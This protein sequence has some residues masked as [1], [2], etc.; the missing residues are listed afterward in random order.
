MFLRILTFITKISKKYIYNQVIQNKN[1][2]EI[3]IQTCLPL[4]IMFSIVSLGFQNHLTELETKCSDMN[5]LKKILDNNLNVIV[6]YRED[7]RKPNNAKMN[8][9]EF[10][11]K[12]TNLLSKLRIPLV[13][14]DCE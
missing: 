1:K 9:A 5:C 12:K 7:T 13:T 11:V 4:I 6:Y 8:Q 10:L 2:K 14:V 3:M